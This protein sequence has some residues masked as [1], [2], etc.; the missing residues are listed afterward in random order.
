MQS[1]GSMYF[2]M[3]GERGALHY[4][5]YCNN[6]TNDLM[7]NLTPENVTQH[8]RIVAS[9]KVYMQTLHDAIRCAFV[10]LQICRPHFEL[11]ITRPCFMYVAVLWNAAIAGHCGL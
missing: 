8:S 11:F 4:I 5:T 3:G 6:K 2:S 9:C 1:T 10:G 7:L